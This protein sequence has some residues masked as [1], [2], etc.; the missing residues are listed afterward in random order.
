MKKSLSMETMFGDV[1]FYERFPCAREAAE[2]YVEFGQWTELDLTRVKEALAANQLRLASLLGG[3]APDLGDAG[4]HNFFLENLSQTIAVGIFLSCTNVML[5]GG[6]PPAA[7]V[8]QG[9]ASLSHAKRLLQSA[10]EKAARSGVTLYLQPMSPEGLSHVAGAA[11]FA[12]ATQ[13]AAALLRSIASPALRLCLNFSPFTTV[14]N[15]DADALVKI[16]ERYADILGYVRV[17]D[18]NLAGLAAIG[19]LLRERLKYDGF[20]GFLLHSEGRK[21]ASLRAVRDF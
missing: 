2:T 13:K 5:E 21:E 7:G 19:R 15:S 3:R 17:G 4:K 16:A 6:F 20:V 14:S 9:E 12:D 8:E 18:S 11:A 10:G 1:D